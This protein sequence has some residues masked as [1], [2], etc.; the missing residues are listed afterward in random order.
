MGDY[1]RYAYVFRQWRDGGRSPV[2]SGARER[3]NL[4]D[5]SE[6]IPSAYQIS[7]FLISE[8]GS[9]STVVLRVESTFVAK[10]GTFVPISSRVSL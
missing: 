4:N 2:G 5:N 1:P 6:M 9:M 3:W 10:T 7:S 8:L